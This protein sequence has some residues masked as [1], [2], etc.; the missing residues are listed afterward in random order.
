MFVRPMRTIAALAFAAALIPSSFGKAPDT[1]DNLHLVASKKLDAVYMADGA[2]FR[3]YTKVMLDPVQVA[4][5]KNW[6]RDYNDTVADPSARISDADAQKM[7]DEIRTGFDPIFAQAFTDAGYQ[8]V[9]APGPDVLRVSTAVIDIS[10]AAPD[11]MTA[12]RSM[13]FSEEA[14]SAALV[15]EVSDSPSGAILGR[16]I[17]KRTVGNGMMSMRSGVSNRAD[18]ERLFKTWAASAAAGMAVLK[19]MSPVDVSAQPR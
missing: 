9:T 13:S 17:D 14:G 1:W 3:P 5:R 7:L 4:F 11:K 12:G 18:A 8:V 2:D 10:V 19:E 16:A 6:R 15:I